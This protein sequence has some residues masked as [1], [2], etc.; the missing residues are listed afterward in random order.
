M[1]GFARLPESESEADNGSTNSSKHDHT[2]RSKS[3][4]TRTISVDNSRYVITNG[5]RSVSRAGGL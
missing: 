5:S 2:E 4:R 1:G 3:C